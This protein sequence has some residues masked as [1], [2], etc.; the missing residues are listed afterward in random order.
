MNVL[1]ERA[2]VS[3]YG[4]VEDFEGMSERGYAHTASRC[5]DGQELC[6]S[7]SARLRAR[8]ANSQTAA[9]DRALAQIT[10]RSDAVCRLL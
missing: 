1:A 8:R 10:L 5:M 9:K 2:D 7:Y 4:P 6:M 3:G